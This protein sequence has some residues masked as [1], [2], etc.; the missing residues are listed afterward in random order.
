MDAHV[1][2]DNSNIFKGAQRAAQAIEPAV[3]RTLVRLYDRNFFE[4]L[5][6]GFNPLTRVLAGSVPPGNEDLWQYARNGGYGT[7]LLRRVETLG[8]A[9]KEQGVD[10][11][12]HLKIAHVLLDYDPPQTLVIATGDA[13]TSE[14]GTSFRDEVERALRRG[15]NVCIW[16]WRAQIGGKFQRQMERA[17]GAMTIHYLDDY[18]FEVTFGVGGRVVK[19]LG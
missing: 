6:R 4:L 17:K 12:L 10:E 19:R 18:Y 13:A 5:E 15:W 11:I 2:V 3:D 14:F 1:F 8:G 16:S 9:R 7:D